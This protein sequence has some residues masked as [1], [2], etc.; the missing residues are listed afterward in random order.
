[1]PDARGEDTPRRSRSP[2]AR[3]MDDTPGRG[4]TGRRRGGGVHKVGEEEEDDGVLG[5]HAG[6]WAAA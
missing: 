4:T 6:L 1:M 5:E 2:K 3:A